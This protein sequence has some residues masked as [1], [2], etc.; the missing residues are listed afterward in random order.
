MWIPV[1]ELVIYWNI[2][3]ANMMMAKQQQFTTGNVQ[4]FFIHKYLS[5]SSTTTPTT[6]WKM[7]KGSVQFFK[8]NDDDDDLHIGCIEKKKMWKKIFFRIQIKK[9]IRML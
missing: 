8:I 2:F 4:W 9:W 5:S 1:M 7:E 3:H 6:K